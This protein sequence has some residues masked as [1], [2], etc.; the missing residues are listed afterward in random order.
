MWTVDV[1]SQRL[2]HATLRQFLLMM[3]VM[4]RDLVAIWIRNIP[5]FRFFFQ[6][7]CSPKLVATCHFYL[8]SIGT[9]RNA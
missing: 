3:R 8:I 5:I 9:E 6:K 7:H 4:R 2:Q 1:E